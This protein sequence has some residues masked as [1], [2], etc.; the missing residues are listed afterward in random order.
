MTLNNKV[1][2]GVVRCRSNHRRRRPYPCAFLAEYALVVVREEN[3]DF[4]SGS[5]PSD[6]VVTVGRLPVVGGFIAT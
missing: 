6:K 3:L 5:V 4:L 2:Y 1:P